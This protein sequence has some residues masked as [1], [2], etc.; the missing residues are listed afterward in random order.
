MSIQKKE[1]INKNGKKTVKYYA[2]VWDKARKKNIWSEGYLL[3]RDA[4][5]EEERLK[6]ELRRGRTFTKYLVV[7][8]YVEWIKYIKTRKSNNTYR[9][10]LDCVNS[11][12]KDAFFDVEVSSILPIH[13]ENWMAELSKQSPKNKPNE[14]LKPS[15]INKAL[16]VFSS[17]MQ[18][19]IRPLHI[20]TQNPCHDVEQYTLPPKQQ[21]VWT[22]D[23]INY[24]LSLQS[25]KASFY[26]DMLCL[27]FSTAMAPEEVC[28]V[29]ESDLKSSFL[30]LHQALDKYDC[31]S[32]MKRPGRHR[33]LIIPDELA[34]LLQKR[35]ALKNTWRLQPDFSEND[36]LFTY[37][38]GRRINPNV[39]SRNFKKLL[40]NYNM[41]VDSYIK[42]HG[43]HPFGRLPEMTLYGGRHSFASNTLEERAEDGGNI[44]VVSE[45]MG[46][47]VEV[48]LR[49]YAHLAPTMHK[50]AIRN[51]TSKIL[52][53]TETLKKH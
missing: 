7:D 26:Y 18:Y 37:K 31:I 34:V 4:K 22:Q 47:S 41:E 21:S 3:K 17:M 9:G 6:R 50:E 13:I 51:Y 44:K 11:Y 12:I 16:S 14:K 10:Y 38:D 36:L 40:L 1:Y 29:Q 2:V 23:Q 35:L 53:K 48:M 25:V 8:L 33:K 45:I 24:F 30:S 19:A 27:S 46:N 43:S 42:K 5:D 28:G 52:P 32:D 15:T 49:H 20:I 39:Y